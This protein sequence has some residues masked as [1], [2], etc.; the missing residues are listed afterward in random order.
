MGKK[1]W[2]F[3]ILGLIILLLLILPSSITG[4]SVFSGG[5]E[6]D[7]FAKC[8]TE[9]NVKMYGAYWCPHCQNQKKLFGSSWKYVTYV[10][11][12]LPNAQ[13]QTDECKAAGIEGYPTWDFGSGERQSGE[14]TIAQISQLSGCPVN[15]Q[16]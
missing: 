4:F 8:L 6:Y 10:E 7:S 5:G 12:S 15:L 14:L 13:G 1:T 9:K 2:I 11:C 3:G 16:E